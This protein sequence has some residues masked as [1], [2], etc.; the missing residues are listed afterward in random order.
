MTSIM[1]TLNKPVIVSM[2]TGASFRLLKVT[3]KASI[4]MPLHY[5]TEEVEFGN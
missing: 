5:G 3:D 1:R 4:Q 2:K